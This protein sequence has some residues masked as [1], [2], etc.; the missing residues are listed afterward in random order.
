MPDMTDYLHPP[1]S[2]NLPPP[3]IPKEI[4]PGII[5][6][7]RRQAL[8]RRQS[9]ESTEGSAVL[10]SV[11]LTDWPASI[12]EGDS[13]RLRTLED[14]EAIPI[15]LEEVRLAVRYNITRQGLFFLNRFLERMEIDV[16]TVNNRLDYETALNKLIGERVAVDVGLIPRGETGDFYNV[17]NGDP[18]PY[19][20]AAKA[21]A[22]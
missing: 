9:A 14:G 13:R 3:V 12:P 2:W 11:V 8:D 1:A 6:S 7:Y 20:P 18:I 19:S 15:D 5:K 4:Y 21:A 17:V 16:Q 10:I 22:E